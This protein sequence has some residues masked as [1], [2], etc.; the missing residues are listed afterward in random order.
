MVRL[1]FTNGPFD[2]GSADIENT[3]PARKP[4]KKRDRRPKKREPLPKEAYIAPGEGAWFVYVY[5]HRRTITPSSGEYVL[6]GWVK[7][8][9][10]EDGLPLIIIEP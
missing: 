4:G 9:D 1:F 2:G 10:V 6:R 3:R 7:L 5:Q 8:T